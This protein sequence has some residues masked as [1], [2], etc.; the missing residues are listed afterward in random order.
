M[1]QDLSNYRRSYE[2]D[3]LLENS[4][5][6]IPFELFKNWF[7]QVES[8]QKEEVNAMTLSTIGLDGFPKGRIVLLKKYSTAGFVF[9]TNYNS[10]KGQSMEI[11]SK[12]CLSFFW[13]S[14]ERQ[15]I[16]KGKIQKISIEESQ[17][18]F[19]SRPKGSQIGAMISNQ[20]S[21]I[22]SREFLD[23]KLA[24]A[25]LEF[26]DKP[27]EKPNN[28]GGYIVIP[29]EFEF[30]QGRE[31]RLHDRIRYKFNDNN[32]WLIERLSP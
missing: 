9:F 7:D 4:I 18:Y 27:V 23:N 5:S 20:S 22:S 10:E 8:N 13:E 3:E 25:T 28:W 19:K 21:V 6:K 11:N 26:Q 15:V 17:E 24:Q 2:K 16:I 29:H 12:V 32:D 30:W 31:N 1:N 14:M